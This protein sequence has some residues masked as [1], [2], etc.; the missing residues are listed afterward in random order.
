MPNVPY[1][2]QVRQSPLPGARFNINAN[3]DSFGAAVGRGIGAVGDAVHAER[4]HAIKAANEVADL[5]SQN[6]LSSWENDNVYGPQGALS[7][8]GKDAIGSMP[9]DTLSS[10]DKRVAEISGGLGNDYQRQKF[11]ER[12]AGMRV[13]VDRKIQDHVAGQITA[14]DQTETNARLQNLENDAIASPGDAALTTAEMRAEIKAHADRNGLPPEWTQ[15]QQDTWVS[16]THLKTLD[17]LSQAGDSAGAK[18]YYDKFSGDIKGEDKT[19]ATKLVEATALRTR[20]QTIEDDITLKIGTGDL[21]TPDEV[22]Q[23]AKDAAGDDAVLRDESVQRAKIALATHRQSEE[24]RHQDIYNAADEA[25]SQRARFADIPPSIAGNL[26]AKE[27]KS[28]QTM[29]LQAATA[30][31]PDD[32]SDTY[33]AL[34]GLA[35]PQ[36]SK[37][38]LALDLRTK[39]QFL[40]KGDYGRLIDLQSDMRGKGGASSKL[41]I[42]IYSEAQEIGKRLR[43]LGIDPSVTKEDADPRAIAFTDQ[44]NRDKIAFQ[45][46]NGREATP[47]E[48]GEMA[49]RNLADV[50]VQGPGRFLSDDWFHDRKRTDTFKRFQ[51]PPPPDEER[52]KVIRALAEEGVPYPSEDQILDTYR[53][54]LPRVPRA[55]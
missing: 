51:A 10:Y 22:V 33:Y 21:S 15:L 12:A 26:T 25:F 40:S 30:N 53:L 24:M 49:D 28:F 36:T 9:E 5:D 43:P 34:R 39:R 35:T 20:A 7:K 27:K 50:A 44:L 29:E 32:N 23:A 42:G 38:F 47:T 46:A 18:A 48:V 54:G 6:K 17:A 55:E 1:E 2:S 31:L 4:I 11:R 16:N 3:A 41:A 52:Q 13:A 8:K 45:A 14:Y 19:K 37:D